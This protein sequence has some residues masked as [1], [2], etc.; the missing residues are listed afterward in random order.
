MA[1]RRDQHE[2]RN[3][4]T[5]ERRLKQTRALRLAGLVLLTWAAGF[6]AQRAR[7]A[8]SYHERA[9]PTR[10]WDRTAR[11]LRRALAVRPADRDLALD[12]IFVLEQGGRAREAARYLESHPRLWRG[13]ELTSAE[14]A[15]RRAP[16]T[17]QVTATG[18][19]PTRSDRVA[20]RRRRL[21]QT[22]ERLVRRAEFETSLQTMRC[23]I[24]HRRQPTLN[25]KP[26]TE[27]LF[28]DRRLLTRAARLYAQAQRLGGREEQQRLRYLLGRTEF[29]ASELFP[30]GHREA[31]QHLEGSIKELTAATADARRSD[32]WLEAV[33]YLGL[34]E[35]KRGRRAEA[36]QQWQRAIQTRP[37][38]PRAWSNLA[39]LKFQQ[40]N[41]PASVRLMRRAVE[42]DPSEARLR[43]NLGLLLAATGDLPAALQEHREAIR[44]DP[45]LAVARLNCALVL[46]SQGQTEAALREL[47][48]ALK[49]APQS[50]SVHNA[51]GRVLLSSGHESEAMRHFQLATQC[52]P[53]Y[54]EA[55]RNLALL[56]RDRGER[57]RSA[58]MFRR[59]LERIPDDAQAREELRRLR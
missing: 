47:Q 20:R 52:N 32:W 41:L 18:R 6:D 58:A 21:V 10:H 53:A 2:V 51:L 9:L 5:P 4:D 34:A 11:Q 19:E 48:Q 54:A 38:D 57:D 56:L 28:P 55:Y 30:P 8:A 33:N 44:L 7:P 27:V 40:G 26:I 39:N 17:S 25:S 3:V 13:R 49:L 35:Q 46:A 37:D 45:R 24:C 1:A 42:N 50:A 14:R 29:K 36:E 15:R 43:T 22:A 23:Q 12:L 16:I 31:K 59:V